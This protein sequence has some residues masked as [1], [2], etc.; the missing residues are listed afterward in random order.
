M[1]ISRFTPYKQKVPTLYN[2][3]IF[4][5]FLIVFGRFETISR[6]VRKIL[7]N[8][9]IYKRSNSHYHSETKIILTDDALRLKIKVSGKFNGNEEVFASDNF[10]PMYTAMSEYYSLEDLKSHNSMLEKKE[11]AF[12]F[13]NSYKL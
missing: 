10:V 4:R 13:E 5:F 1:I 12:V 9:L 8:L 7:Q 2:Y 3:F 11:D 6:L